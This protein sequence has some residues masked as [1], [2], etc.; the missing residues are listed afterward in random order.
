MFPHL[1]TFRRFFFFLMFGL[2]ISCGKELSVPHLVQNETSPFF[3]KTLFI[4][5]DTWW[6]WKTFDLCFSFNC[7]SFIRGMLSCPSSSLSTLDGRNK[8]LDNHFSSVCFLKLSEIILPSSWI[9]PLFLH[10]YTP[11]RF[12][13]V[14]CRAEKLH[15]LP[16][17]KPL[18]VHPTDALKFLAAVCS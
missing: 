5:E 18:F 9:F 13:T 2:F 10:F 4:L 1:T 12:S 15:S 7:I 3:M 8:I 17:M 14:L 16:L 6:T 11:D